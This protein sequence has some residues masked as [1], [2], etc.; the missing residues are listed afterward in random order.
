MENRNNSKS[1]SPGAFICNHGISEY[2]F[3][4][5]GTYA[6]PSK[7]ANDKFN[8]NTV[9]ERIKNKYFGIITTGIAPIPVEIMTEIKKNF[10]L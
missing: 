10:Y 3:C 6:W 2:E 1:L 5:F 7:L 9:I 8:R 4:S